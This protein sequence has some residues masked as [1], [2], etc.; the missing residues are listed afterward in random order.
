MPFAPKIMPDIWRGGHLREPFNIDLHF[1]SDDTDW[2]TTNLCRNKWRTGSTRFDLENDFGF[3]LIVPHRD[4]EMGLND[5]TQI[6]DGM[7]T[8]RRFIF[9]LSR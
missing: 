6:E 7:Q 1:S 5:A 4:S 3:K 2:V 9:V 8:S